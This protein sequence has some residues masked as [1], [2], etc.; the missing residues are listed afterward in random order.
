MQKSAGF[1]TEDNGNKS[2]I[3]LISFLCLLASIGFGAVACVKPKEET[4]A[5]TNLSFTFLTA[6]I[7]GKV[8]QKVLETKM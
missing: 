3:R 8:G 4:A 1:F 5:A 7:A 2:M 6:A